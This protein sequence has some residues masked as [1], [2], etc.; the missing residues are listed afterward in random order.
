MIEGK[1]VDTIDNDADAA[2]EL[3]D[4]V[5]LNAGRKQLDLGLGIDGSHHLRHHLDFRLADGVDCSAK[6]AIEV[7]DVEAVEVGQ[8]KP[9]DAHARQCQEMD[10]A[11]PAGPGDGDTGGP[12][13]RLLVL[14]DQPDVA[15]ECPGVKVRTK[16]RHVYL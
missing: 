12:K 11:H 3:C 15:L 4:V 5:F 14:R 1:E 7:A 6:L 9:T 8:M 2:Q 10:A 13:P 16:G